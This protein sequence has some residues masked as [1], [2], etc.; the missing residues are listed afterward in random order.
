MSQM[1]NPPQD[2][3]FHWQSIKDL[4]DSPEH[5]NQVFREFPKQ[6]S[7]LPEG[8]S[9]RDF[10]KLMGG[11]LALAGSTSC[12]FSIRKPAQSIFPYASQPEH[13][14]PGQ[15]TFY[16][17]AHNVGESVHAL[18]AESYEGRPI[19]VEGNPE[20][21]S[22]L[23]ASSTIDQASVLGLYDPDRLQ[24]T[25]QKGLSVPLILFKEFLQNVLIPLMRTNQGSDVGF[26]FPTVRSPVLSS[27]L[28]RV[29]AQYPKVRLYHYEPINLDYFAQASQLAYGS[30]ALPIYDVEPADIIVSVGYDFLAQGPHHLAYTKHFAARRDPDHPKGMNRLYVFEDGFTPTG[31]KADHRFSIRRQDLVY[32]LC[33]LFIEIYPRRASQ[34][35]SIPA[36]VMSSIQSAAKRCYDILPMEVVQILRDDLLSHSGRSMVCVGPDL[37]AFVQ[38]L[39]IWIN[40]ALYNSGKTLRYGKIWDSRMS[41]DSL[42]SAQ[43][44]IQDIQSQKLLT[45][46][47]LDVDLFYQFPVDIRP[48]DVPLFPTLITLTDQPN[49]T[50]KASDWVIPKKHYLESWGDA[51]DLDGSVALQQPLIQSLYPDAININELLSL[52]L[53]QDKSDFDLVRLHYKN[54]SSAHWRKDLH[55]GFSAPVYSLKTLSLKAL[56]SA[57]ALGVSQYFTT[58]NPRVF[59]RVDAWELCFITDGKMHD[60]RYINN[61]WL[62]ELPDPIIKVAWDNALHIGL[63]VAE[64]LGLKEGDLVLLTVGGRSIQVPV[65]PIPGRA[66]RSLALAIGY[67]QE[68]TGRIGQGSGKNANALRTMKEFHCATQKVTVEKLGKKY[69]LACVQHHFQMSPAKGWEARPFALETTLET[70]QKGFSALKQQAGFDKLTKVQDDHGQDIAFGSASLKSLWDEKVYD[71][72]VAPHQWGMSI[73]LS[74]CTA[75]GACTLACSAENNIPIVGKQQMQQGR[76]MHWIRM[77]RYFMGDDLDAPKMIVQPVACLHCENAPCEQVCPVAATVHSDEGTNDMVYNRCIGTRYCSNNCPYKVRRFNFFDYHQNHPQA[78][79]NVKKHLFDAPKKPAETISMQFN[80]DVSI[81]MRGVMEKCTYCMQRI[82]SAHV[83]SKVEGRGLIRDGEIQSAC[84]Q[85]CAAGAI[86]FGNIL[87]TSS[88][89][90]RQKQNIRN[91]DILGELNTKPRTSYLASVTNPHPVLAGMVL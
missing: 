49:A 31:G 44:L 30:L 53:G 7:E 46:V 41:G 11:S 87:D 67:G 22:N 83:Q 15:P 82:R 27:L 10:L 1:K 47:S 70:Y 25:L 24:S 40:H 62:Q 78:E 32:V 50:A 20:F 12:N 37:P 19:K 90:F 85:V 76:E 58:L 66:K 56:S 33:A 35:P 79:E 84:S 80:P 42:A 5:R 26:L 45:L 51:V 48:Q 16:A 88:A 28:D 14:V 65:F 54:K 55:Q 74:K 61:A 8:I 36:S 43:R 73:D 3:N 57:S 2:A 13:L 38:L 81:R 60:G 86:T 52:F 68:H 72:S 17:T 29:Q 63:S 23:G 75:C 39:G 59:P 89:V 77:D 69:P 71:E 91:Y 34:F 9:R 21:S 64:Q 6:A 4:K 18:L